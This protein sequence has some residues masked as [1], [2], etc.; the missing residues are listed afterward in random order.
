MVRRMTW[1]K[2]SKMR[3]D[4]LTEVMFATAVAA[5]CI[6]LAMTSMNRSL[7]QSQMAVE[8]TLTRQ[9]IDAEADMLRYVHD[10][11][12]KDRTGSTGEPK[13]WRD[14]VSRSVSNASAFGT[15]YSE[16]VDPPNNSF[17]V[18]FPDVSGADDMTRLELV[19]NADDFSM[20][21]T[22]AD[23][24]KGIWVEA[25]R[26]GNPGTYYLDL[27]IR[28]CWEP[29]YSGPEATLGTIVRLYYE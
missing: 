5:L 20:P 10:E 26:G 3:G 19:T 29:P 25:V 11:Y 24:G 23:I 15:C 27:H 17:F 18:R 6:V 9:S 1:Q 14:I 4:T 21:E 28:A 7:A 22:N 16:T 2:N 12:M 8:T 13:M